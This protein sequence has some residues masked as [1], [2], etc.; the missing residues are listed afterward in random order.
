VVKEKRL[1]YDLAVLEPLRA[2][3]MEPVNQ[4]FKA[5]PQS[6]A[7]LL[8]KFMAFL[9]ALE[10]PKNMEKMSRNLSDVEQEKDEQVWKSF[11]HL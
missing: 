1:V 7:T 8:E 2:K 3:I 10:F 5:G 4:L 9:E 11:T 6:G